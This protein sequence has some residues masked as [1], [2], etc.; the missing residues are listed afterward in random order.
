MEPES[1][2][3]HSQ[4]PATC[5]CPQP[6]HFLFHKSKLPAS[7][8]KHHHSQQKLKILYIRRSSGSS[9]CDRKLGPLVPNL[10]Q[11][12]KGKSNMQAV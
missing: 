7:I 6:D 5:A 12:Q 10:H 3:P 11:I 2:I 4:D 9:F 1:S 8:H